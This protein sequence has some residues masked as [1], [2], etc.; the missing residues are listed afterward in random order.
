MARIRKGSFILQPISNVG[1][2]LC[3]GGVV[4]VMVILLLMGFLHFSF[5]NIRLGFLQRRY[6]LFL[7]WVMGILLQG[8][9]SGLCL[10]KGE[11]GLV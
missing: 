7:G 11:G 4:I 2:F 10:G 3:L 6:F 9:F 5:C 8:G 1:L